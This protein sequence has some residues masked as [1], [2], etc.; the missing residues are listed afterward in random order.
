MVPSVAASAR[1]L[2]AKLGDEAE[3]TYV[4]LA[5]AV[6]ENQTHVVGDLKALRDG[7]GQM[8]ID[9]KRLSLHL[10]TLD[11][12]EKESPPP[13]GP[14]NLGRLSACQETL[15]G[16]ARA[17]RTRTSSSID[18][19]HV[20]CAHE[21]I[22]N[23]LTT[24]KLALEVSRYSLVLKVLSG[25][26][27]ASPTWQPSATKI[28]ALIPIRIPKQL[29]PGHRILDALC[30]T[31]HSAA[32]ALD[33]LAA[34][35]PGTADWVLT[36]HSGVKDW[37]Q[38][39]HKV[40]HLSGSSGCG[41][42]VI[43]ATIV[44]HLAQKATSPTWS[45]CYF[46]IDPRVPCNPTTILGTLLAQI[47]AQSLQAYSMAEKVFALPE[48]ENDNRTT[49]ALR[50]RHDTPDDE[51]VRWVSYKDPQVLAKILRAAMQSFSKNHVVIDGINHLPPSHQR[52]GH[53][54]EFSFSKRCFFEALS[55]ALAPN[56]ESLQELEPASDLE[57][58]F[59]FYFE[60]LMVERTTTVPLGLAGL[61]TS[62]TSAPVTQYSYRHWSFV[63]YLMTPTHG[64]VLNVNLEKASTSLALAA[65]RYM[66]LA[67]FKQTVGGIKL[68]QQRAY[69]RQ[70][71]NPFYSL[72]AGW[73][74][75]MLRRA[76]WTSLKSRLL[77][78][79]DATE[80]D[81]SILFFLEYF[82]YHFPWVYELTSL[83]HTP[84]ALIQ[85]VDELAAGRLT[86]FHI[87][88][89]LGLPDVC[90]GTT[91]KWSESDKLA[92]FG[93]STAYGPPLALAILGP[94]AFAI[95]E[96][97]TWQDFFVPLRQEKTSVSS[98]DV[99]GTILYL[100]EQSGR[101]ST[102][103]PSRIGG[104]ISSLAASALMR[105]AF[106]NDADL[107]I[108]LMKAKLW[109]PISLDSTFIQVF[110]DIFFPDLGSHATPVVLYNT[111]ARYHRRALSTD[112]RVF[113]DKICEYMMDRHMDLVLQPPGPRGGAEEEDLDLLLTTAWNCAFRYELACAKFPQE[114]GD[115][116]IARRPINCSDPMYSRLRERSLR[117][118]KPYQMLR[119]MQDPRWDVNQ[120]L[121]NRGSEM[122]DENAG[123]TALHV[124][125][126]NKGEVAYM[127]A[128]VLIRTGANVFARDA[129]GRTPLHMAESESMLKLLLGHGA[130]SQAQD[131][132]GRTVWHVAA[133][134]ND[135]R[136]LRELVEWQ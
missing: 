31:D 38:G 114:R 20:A 29:R 106:L 83:Y 47:M 19:D 48:V 69:E 7:L 92:L 24:L 50:S 120:P 56:A 98:I 39:N 67:E 41:K 113:L 4:L 32:R 12:P 21:V 108:H 42:S 90:R 110:D 77:V 34:R 111:L 57:L 119:L 117:E 58:R 49:T 35:C 91:E 84:K 59:S 121:E 95:S 55:L 65:L 128:K 60:A 18:P 46:F 73:L 78:L 134:N 44:N 104:G 93:K 118:F 101:C 8:C 16:L 122:W 81:S 89:S 107:F 115:P 51:T 124:T 135:A 14:Y 133:A 130:E 6:K 63:E 125:V 112:A 68:L 86:A 40:L 10:P 127:L 25:R 45:L 23:T 74:P 37:M 76:D 30:T 131:L 33:L 70:I 129:R 75:E 28:P 26:P 102:K 99:R 71:H 3:D 97:E 9:L 82:N 2:L 88:V 72:A 66:G 87:A 123:Q 79:F 103:L 13:S 62:K 116:E 36:D 22:Q 126:E 96:S 1:S 54:K 52:P 53:F 136:T 100:L 105:C 132:D 17:L 64:S 80:R 27:Q 85:L 94:R 43:A 15:S 61:G 109:P 5:E 11:N